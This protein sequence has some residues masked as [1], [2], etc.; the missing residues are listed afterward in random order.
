MYLLRY[1]QEAEK[2]DRQPFKLTVEFRLVVS[3][4][5]YNRSAS[6]SAWR[7]LEMA[8]LLLQRPFELY[9]VSRPFNAFPQEL[10][11]RFGLSLIWDHQP[12]GGSIGTAPPYDDLVEDICALLTLLSRRLV[13]P[14]LETRVLS[15]P[16]SKS[17]RSDSFQYD[18][19]SPIIGLGNLRSRTMRTSRSDVSVGKGAIVE[20]TPPPLG[21]D[22]NTLAGAFFSLAQSECAS[23][24]LQAARAYS[25][26]LQLMLTRPELAYQLLISS[27]ETVA[28]KVCSDYR[29]SQEDMIE[30]KRGVHTKAISFRLSTEQADSL[31]VEACRDEHWLGRKFRT[32]FF[33]Y[34]SFEE[35]GPDE[36]FPL[37]DGWEP[38]EEDFEK[39]LKAIY[40]ARSKHLHEGKEFPEWIGWG[41]SAAIPASWYPA[42]SNG[43]NLVPPVTWFERLVSSTLKCLLAGERNADSPEPFV[44]A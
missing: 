40:S 22:G 44:R 1:L 27:V 6:S 5:F 20:H 29:P 9:V 33:R 3:G 18:H 17:M 19:P 43:S 12:G 39:V 26:A 30:H 21:V 24:V 28:N 8:R 10:C 38:K 35:S 37:A 11:L 2:T 15:K 14:A 41:A 25:S 36:M 16:D 7:S 23:A 32:F 31:A 34:R 42:Y 4:E 13:V